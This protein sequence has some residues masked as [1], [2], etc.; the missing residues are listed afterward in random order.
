MSSFSR[1]SKGGRLLI[2]LA[3]WASSFVLAAI[4][5]PPLDSHIAPK[6]AA[7]WS[8]LALVAV[9]TLC[10]L[11]AI[12]AYLLQQWRRLPTVPNRAA[13]GIWLGFE[14]MLLVAI[15][16]LSSYTSRPCDSGRQSLIPP[17]GS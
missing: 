13:Y 12:P 11:I 10:S 1:L 4:V 5:L 3:G 8:I 14:S 7:Y 9:L 2:V 17:G 16:A 6:P 15:P